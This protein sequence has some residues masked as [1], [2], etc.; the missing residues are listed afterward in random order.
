MNDTNKVV[1]RGELIRDAT[2]THT[3]RGNPVTTFTISFANV[4]AHPGGSR[5][6]RGQ[7]D[8]IYYCGE[9]S[10][11]PPLLKKARLVDV[12]G[13]LQ[14]RSWQTPEGIQKRKTEIIA[15]RLSWPGDSSDQTG[16][17]VD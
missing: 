15:D 7:I 9:T 13:S 17:D 6:K 1:L 8:V 4:H 11:L 12:E 14:Q 5:N 16:E 2:F 10:H 3:P